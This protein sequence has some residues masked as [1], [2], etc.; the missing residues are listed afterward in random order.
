MPANADEDRGSDPRRQAGSVA[1]ANHVLTTDQPDEVN[2][3]LLD[4]FAAHED[5]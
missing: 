2:R 1:D 5:A 4:W 3:L